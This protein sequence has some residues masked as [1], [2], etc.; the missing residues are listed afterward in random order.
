MKSCGT[1][2]LFG[3][4]LLSGCVQGDRPVREGIS[5]G[6]KE[7]GCA[8][9]NFYASREGRVFFMLWHDY[10]PTDRAAGGFGSGGVCREGD[11]LEIDG[12]YGT[13]DGRLLQWTC[14]SPD[15]VTGT[16]TVN[17]VE[18]DLEAGN[19]FIVADIEGETSVT[20][21]VRDLGASDSVHATLSS[22]ER[23]EP[24]IQ[25]LVRCEG[26]D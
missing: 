15:G 17:G 10:R 25:R 14:Q 13:T 7:V 1:I 20:R 12:A 23:Q 9:A 19:L 18:Y 22:L 11:R 26:E 4:L 3:L 8:T 5:S 24:D 21:L 6:S 16:V 2:C